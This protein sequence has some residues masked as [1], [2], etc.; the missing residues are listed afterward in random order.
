MASP[1]GYITPSHILYVDDIFVFY[2]MDNKYLKNLSI[3]LK[4]YGDFFGQYVNNSR[5][6]FF[7]MIILQDSLQKFNVIFLAVM[8]F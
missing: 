5:N 8:A 2:R 6:T 1:K 7:T 4:K 3:F